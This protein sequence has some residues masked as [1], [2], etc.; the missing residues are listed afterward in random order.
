VSQE[1][2]DAVQGQLIDRR[3]GAQG[4]RNYG[5]YPLAGISYCTGCSGRLYANRRGGHPYL[6]DYQI[7]GTD[8]G[9]RCG[10]S[11]DAD[12]AEA[13]LREF[14][15]ERF[16][17]PDEAV[18]LA[19]QMLDAEP[20][21]QHGQQRQL[22]GLALDRLKQQYEWGHL[23]EPAY[24]SEYRTVEAQRAMLPAPVSRA[25]LDRSAALLRDIGP[26]LKTGQPEHRR[27]FYHEVLGQVWWRQDGP[28]LARTE[29]LVAV[30]PRPQYAPLFVW[31]ALAESAVGDDF[32]GYS[33]PSRIRAGTSHPTLILGVQPLIERLHNITNGGGVALGGAA[34]VA[35]NGGPS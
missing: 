1:L 26:L 25:R 4:R 2:F 6:M 19:Y 14:L 21:E 33:G 10:L 16:R 12:R 32:G 11:I 29:T 30:R 35:S 5:G 34:F 15:T 8:P 13:Q 17:L 3:R 7:S 23:S 18:E 9:R 31:H 22:L 27:E 20:D 28:R 24:L